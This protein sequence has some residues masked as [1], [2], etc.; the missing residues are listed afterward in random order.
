M[1]GGC[2]ESAQSGGR[3]LVQERAHGARLAKQGF[4]VECIAMELFDQFNEDGIETTENRGQ[5]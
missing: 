2:G 3:S 1:S 5:M 4:H